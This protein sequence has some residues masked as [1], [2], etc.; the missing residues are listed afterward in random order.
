MAACS[1]KEVDAAVR[2]LEQMAE[3]SQRLCFHGLFDAGFEQVRHFIL[4]AWTQTCASDRDR[5]APFTDLLTTL[6]CHSNM[7]VQTAT[8]GG[9]HQSFR[10]AINT[11]PGARRI[12]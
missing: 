3:H 2:V 9:G 12:I 4:E 1:S 11:L 6:K 7:P 8:P 5:L 10:S